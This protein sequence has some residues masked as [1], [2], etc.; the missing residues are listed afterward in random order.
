MGVWCQSKEELEQRLAPLRQTGKL[1]VTTNGCFDIINLAHLRML[2]IAR[3]QGDIL[4]V[5]VNSDQSIRALKGPNRPIRPERERAEIVAAFDNVDFVI[6]F[7]E[8]DCT[9]FV[10]RVR[11]NVHVND[12]SYGENCVESAA[13]R[14]CGGRLVLVPKMEWESNSELIDRIKRGG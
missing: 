11:P 12:A 5:G 2:K 7:D 9:D 8:K 6:L 3:E 10:A 4:V 13:V 1:I 14:E